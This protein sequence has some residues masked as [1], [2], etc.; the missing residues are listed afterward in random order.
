MNEN[1]KLL[2]PEAIATGINKGVEVSK[3]LTDITLLIGSTG[4][5]EYV[6]SDAIPNYILRYAKHRAR[7]LPLF[8]PVSSI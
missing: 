8:T 6:R 1:E 4:P 2:L 5:L 7:G 3:R